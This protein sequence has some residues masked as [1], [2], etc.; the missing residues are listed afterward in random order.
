MNAGKSRLYGLEADLS[1]RPF[2]GFRLVAVPAEE[3]AAANVLSVRG[4]VVVHAGFRRTR[5]LLDR[6]G[7]RVLPLDVSE[8]LK[9]EAGLTCKSLLL[10]ATP[11]D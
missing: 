5:D 2:D 6:E 4:R 1:L 3:H 9:A 11:T 7:Y 10:G 8:F